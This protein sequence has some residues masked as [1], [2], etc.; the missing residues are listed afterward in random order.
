VI[1][2]ETGFGVDRVITGI[3]LPA[4]YRRVDV[5]GIE[6][7]RVAD[8]ADAFGRDQRRTAAEETIEKA[9]SRYGVVS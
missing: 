7:Q 2:G 8:P 5:Q 3:G 6:F 1:E 4:P 9:L